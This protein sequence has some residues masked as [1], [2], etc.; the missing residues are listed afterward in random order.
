MSALRIVALTLVSLLVT[1][2]SAETALTA[3]TRPGQQV[4]LNPMVDGRV[5][6]IFVSEGDRVASGQP[7]LSLDDEVQAAR[8]KL[9]RR[10]A[11][12]L[13]NVEKARQQLARTKQRYERLRSARNGSV[14]KWEIEDAGFQVRIAQADLKLASDALEVEREKLA[15]EQKILKQYHVNAPFPGEVV[16]ITIDPGA[17]VKRSEKLITIADLTTLEAVAF[18]PANRILEFEAGNQ[19]IVEFG[20]PFTQRTTARLRFIDRRLEPASRT[21]RAIFR[22][23]NQ[24]GNI[25]SGTELTILTPNS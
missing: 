11:N 10:S 20:Q 16:E 5:A 21:F 25:P 8:V 1:P 13:G 12:Q 3:I 4:A 17:T 22:I 18:V 24:S 2:A 19:Y 6:K 15:L 9:T 7:L 23:E 14:P